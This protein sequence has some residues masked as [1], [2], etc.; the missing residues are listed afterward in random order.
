MNITNSILLFN[1]IDIV[2]IL[3]IIILCFENIDPLRIKHMN[4]LLLINNDFLG[5]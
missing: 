1:I 4:M 3:N 2:S 5:I